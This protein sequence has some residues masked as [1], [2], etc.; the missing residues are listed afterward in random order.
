[1][2]LNPTRRLGDGNEKV[3][4]ALIAMGNVQSDLDWTQEALDSY[5]EALAICNVLFG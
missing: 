3:A 4:N 5:K 1:M 2:S